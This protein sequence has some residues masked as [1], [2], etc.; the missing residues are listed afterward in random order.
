MAYEYK[1]PQPVKLPRLKVEEETEEDHNTGVSQNEEALNQDISEI[2]NKLADLEARL[3]A[4][5]QK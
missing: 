4:F 5:E 2:A 1:A 3:A